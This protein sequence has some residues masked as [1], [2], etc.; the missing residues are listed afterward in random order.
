M[1]RGVLGHVDVLAERHAY[2]DLD[3]VRVL[4]AKVQPPGVPQYPYTARFSTFLPAVKEQL[5]VVVNMIRDNRHRVFDLSAFIYFEA[6]GKST[7]K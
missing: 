1:G 2:R 7:A 6:V 5:S 3:L 4:R